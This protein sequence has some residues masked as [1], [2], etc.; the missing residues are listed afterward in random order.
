MNTQM[1]INNHHQIIILGCGPSSL[2]AATQLVRTGISV[3][4]IAEEIGGLIQNANLI[5]NLLGF[6]NGITAG[7][8]VAIMHE[9]IIKYQIPVINEK[10]LEVSCDDTQY[11][12]KTVSKNYSCEYL[13]I[14]TGTI[15]NSLQIPGE[16]DA[17]NGN[18]LFYDL[19]KF[20]SVRENLDIG[21]VG[22]GDAAYDYALNLSKNMSNIEILQRNKKST[23]LSLLIQ[24]VN[25]KE[26][27][28]VIT[29]VKV[30]NIEIEANMVKLSLE[31]SDGMISK[32]YNT[33]LV[34]VG[35]SPNISFLSPKLKDYYKRIIDKEQ[36]PAIKTGENIKKIW[37]IGD[38]KNQKHRQLAI[39]MGDGI[40]A[41]M[42]ITAMLHK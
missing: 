5:E 19:Y 20:T 35:R 26:N 31:S 7:E 13:V 12:I 27:I 3:L 9:T 15:P 42:Q 10:I 30:R 28:S 6:P 32:K 23:A 33:V 40:K 11:L 2:S 34:T 18:L 37:F 1:S 22:G 4:I 36:A 29:D 21:I 17:H 38:I 14:G 24:R 39:A 8:M 16:E 41:A 25:E